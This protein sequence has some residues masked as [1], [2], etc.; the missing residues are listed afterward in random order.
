MSLRPGA[1]SDS[2]LLARL[3]T[4]RGGR[5]V[6]AAA[7]PTAATVGAQAL[8]DG[9][10]AFDAAV[11][12]ALAE[13]VLLPPK[14]GLA[15]DVVAMC[16]PGGSTHPE[17]LIGIG[18]AGARL[19]ST[20]EDRGLPQTGALS[21][22]VPGAPAGLAALS[23]RGRLT[24]R[25]HIAPAISLAQRGF[26]WAPILDVLAA[27]SEELVARE[28]PKG[29]VYYP[30]GRRI[31][32]G[33]IVRLPGL[34]RVLEE[35]GDRGADLMAGPVGDAVLDR[36]S[37]AGG[38]LTADDMAAA[39]AQW[40]HPDQVTRHGY[41]IWAT[42]AP[43]HGPSLLEAVSSSHGAT[44]EH[45]WQATQRAIEHRRERLGDPVPD[46]G[47]SV[48]SAVDH[49]GTVVVIVLSNSHPQFG[50]GIVVDEYDLILSNRA[51]RGFSAAAGHPNA[52]VAGR[53]PA[54]TLHAWAAGRHDPEFLGATPGGVNQMIWNAQ[55]VLEI[56]GGQHDPGALVTAPRW[57]WLHEPNTARAEEALGDSALEGLTRASGHVEVV[58]PWSLRSVQHVAR[59]PRP[60]EARVAAVDPRTGAG[61]A[62]V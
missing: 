55:T 1:P 12:A 25:Q 20:V 31:E 14:C 44:P 13:T 54:T 6:V 60:G 45:L 29:T 10:N 40:T 57:Q 62:A 61:V 15:G 43:T 51:G 30:R 32:P 9:G 42:P 49:D 39:A 48:V 46:G 58:A 37:R 34:A 41:T 50:S 53:R 18:P 5:G 2:K 56:T 19:A 33:A 36:V 7:V 59:V 16:L 23:E 11:T 26:A 35:W 47:T 8:L 22:G 38:I 24:R 52:P 4:G 27:E 21:V 17:A 3:Q 28:N